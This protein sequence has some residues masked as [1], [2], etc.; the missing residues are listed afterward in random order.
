MQKTLS[1][2]SAIQKFASGDSDAW[3][4]SGYASKFN[5]LDSYGDTIAPGAFNKVLSDIEAGRA[6]MPKMLLNHNRYEL[7]VGKWLSF[8][9]TGEGLLGEG[10]LTKG[11]PNSPAIRAGM[12]HGTVDGLSI[13]F[14]L[15]KDDYEDQKSGGILI[16]NVAKLFEVSVVTFPADSQ[17]KIDLATVKST[18]DSFGRLAE[19]EDYLRDARGFSRAEAKAMVSAI[20]RIASQSESDEATA[21]PDSV[22]DL[23]IANTINLAL[24]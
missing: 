21:L 22:R 13:G 17:A 7:P 18:L 12:Q 9:E 6:D 10:E 1:F 5:G 11:N 16:K 24:N 8:S 4:F 20:K 2:R 3:T 19:I 15:N 14:G 23:I